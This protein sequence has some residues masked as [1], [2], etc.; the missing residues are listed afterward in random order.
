V[1]IARHELRD[2]DL[3]DEHAYLIDDFPVTKQVLETG[4]PRA[5]SFLDD[6][7]DPAEAIVL[8][9]VQ[10]NCCLLLPLHLHGGPWGLVELYDMRLRR[11]TRDDQAVAEFLVQQAA[12]RLE[13]F[14]ELDEELRP[15]PLFRV[16]AE[17]DDTGS[18]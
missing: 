14:G 18:T 2:I 6:D 3:G 11:F 7:L 5:V 13:S 12:R 17:P 10:M 4:V 9:E 8:R 16:Q 1:D 15:L